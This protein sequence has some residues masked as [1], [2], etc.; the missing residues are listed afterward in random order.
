MAKIIAYGYS[1]KSGRYALAGSFL[2][3]LSS[4]AESLSFELFPERGLQWSS[5]YTS[6]VN[7]PDKIRYLD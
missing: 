2:V 1:V 5:C 4:F 6:G 7:I 3:F